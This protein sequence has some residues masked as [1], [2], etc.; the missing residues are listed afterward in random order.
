MD[1]V[2]FVALQQVYEKVALLVFVEEDV[3]H[4]EMVEEQVFI[5][6]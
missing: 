5:E 2:S 1:G 3:S 6:V 4:E